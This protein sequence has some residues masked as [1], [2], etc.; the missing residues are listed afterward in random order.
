MKGKHK[1]KRIVTKILKIFG[2]IFL[3]IVLLLIVIALAVHLPPVQNKLV[4]KAVSFLEDKIGTKVS[5]DHISISFPKAI[6][7]E[8]LYL[9]DQKKDTLLYAGKFRV[10]T[11]LWALT[12][13]EIQL[14]D[15]TLTKCRAYVNRPENDSSYNFSYIL[16]AFAGDSTATKDTVQESAWKFSIEDIE[17]EDIRAHY[18]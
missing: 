13:K 5:L 1:T 10:D 11:D 7:L 12:K 17:L 9:E 18:N 2:W 16:K 8:G 3:S 6:V 14:N 4:Q 15:I